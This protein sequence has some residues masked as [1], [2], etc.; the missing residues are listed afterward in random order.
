MQWDQFLRIHANDSDLRMPQPMKDR[1]IL[2]EQYHTM[3]LS[4]GHVPDN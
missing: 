1:S 2:D 4:K 3:A